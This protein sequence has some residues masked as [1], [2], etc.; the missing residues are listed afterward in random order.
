MHEAL[1]RLSSLRV[2]RARPAFASRPTSIR[3]TMRRHARSSGWAS[4]RKAICASAGSSTDVVSDTDALRPPAPRVAAAVI[5]RD[6]RDDAAAICAIYNRYVEDTIVSFEETPVPAAEMAERIDDAVHAPVVR[7]V[8]RTGSRRRLRV[9]RTVATRAAYRDAV[10]TTVYVSIRALD[11]S[12]IGS[13]LY[14]ALLAELRAALGFHCVHGRHRPAQRGERRAARA[15][16]LRQGRPLPRGR[17]EVRADGSTSGIGNACCDVSGG[18]A[19]RDSGAPAI[20]QVATHITARSRSW[21]TSSFA[22]S[23]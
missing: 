3:A 16:G 4:S 18:R 1:Q 12:G 2:R 15:H 7:S 6:D 21:P 8:S 5:R 23:P 22:S 20:A 19:I 17:M 10:E 13:Q 11:G 14:D 9:R